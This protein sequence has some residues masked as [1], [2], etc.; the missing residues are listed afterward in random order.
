MLKN[1]KPISED[2]IEDLPITAN[3]LNFSK[4]A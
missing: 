1:V 4:H 2:M 3:D